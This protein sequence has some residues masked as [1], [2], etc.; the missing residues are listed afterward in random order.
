MAPKIT[1]ILLTDPDLAETI[2]QLKGLISRRY[3]PELG[4]LKVEKTEYDHRCHPSRKVTE[5]T[6]AVQRIDYR[7]AK[8]LLFNLVSAK[9]ARGT[10]PPTANDLIRSANELAALFLLKR[11]WWQLSGHKFFPLAYIVLVAI[12]LC[13]AAPAIYCGLKECEKS[14]WVVLG[15]VAAISCD[16]LEAGA[17]ACTMIVT[18][19][20]ARDLLCLFILPLMGLAKFA[21]K[22]G[23]VSGVLSAEAV[24]EGAGEAVLMYGR[25]VAV[26]HTQ[27]T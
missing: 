11:K 2:Q 13:A 27:P 12:F 20:R 10:P 1:A 17:L 5:L 8:R 24:A 6:V 14:G 4:Q 16:I 9:L 22:L 25:F 26:V 3:L 23:K 19:D 15:V 18:A 7:E 21:G